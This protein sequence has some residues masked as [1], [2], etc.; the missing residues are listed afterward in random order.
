M[1]PPASLGTED[2]SRFLTSLAVEGQVAPST[3]GQAT[4][5]LL[6]LYRRVLGWRVGWLEGIVRAKKAHHLPVVLTRG[7]VKSLLDRMEG[8]AKLAA[9]LLYGAGLRITECLRL[10]V[11]DVDLARGEIMVRGGKGAKD[12]VTVLP[13]LARDPIAEHL[14]CLRERHREALREG[15]G[16]VPLP[17]AFVRKSPGA[18][19]EWAWQWLMPARRDWTHPRTGERLRLPLHESAIQRAVRLAAKRAG[20]AKRVTCHAL[21]HSFATHLLEDGYD[22]RTVQELLGHKDVA[23]TMIYTHVLNRGGLAVRSPA[24]RL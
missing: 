4:A 3:Q 19:A 14:G 9:M 16:R 12:R 20:I 8:T 7:E 22:I 13:R 17:A 2:V 11:K 23:T 10:R 1:S 21:R 5:A 15:G 18:A 6:F 24:D